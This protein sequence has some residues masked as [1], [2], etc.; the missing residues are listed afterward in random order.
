MTTTIKTFKTCFKC[1][2]EKPMTAF[3]V[4][5]Q[6]GD[7]RLNK[8]KEC[9]KKDAAKNLKDNQEYYREYE[10]NRAHLPHRVKQRNPTR[11]GKI[12][13][14]C[15][16]PKSH[17]AYD[18]ESAGKSWDK[19]NPKKRSASTEAYKALLRGDL[20]KKPCEVCGTDEKIHA[21]HCDYS[22]PLDVMWLCQ[23][24]HLE[25]HKNHGAIL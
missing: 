17:A 25:W 4:H 16:I 22:K 3:Y 13:L 12:G 14:Y 7:G 5:P 18:T 9:A 2:I 23:T 15:V 21:H 11:N 8:C 20:I 24:H 10:R 19:R 1:H 6:M